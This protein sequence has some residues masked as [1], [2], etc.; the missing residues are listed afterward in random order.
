M[1]INLHFIFLLHLVSLIISNQP[2]QIK[3]FI[4][5]TTTATNS[6]RA[7]IRGIRGSRNNQ[8]DKAYS[9]LS[10]SQITEQLYKLAKSYPDFVT[11][12]TT[13]EEFG[14]KTA[15]SS[16]DCQFDPHHSNH[17]NSNVG[18]YNY[19]LTIQDFIS[20]PEHSTSSQYLP[21]IF[22]SGAV[23]GNERV[24]PA[25]VVETAA[26]LLESA[27]CESLPHV[28]PNH[29]I[30]FNTEYG[31]KLLLQV[32]KGTD[33]RQ[34]LY[35][36]GISNDQRQWLARL[37]STRRI[38]IMPTA[39]ALGYHRNQREEG[40]IDPN[41][42]FP[43]DVIDKRLCMQT[44]AGR[45]INELFRRHLFQIALTFHGGME[46]VS[47]EWG[48]PSYSGKQSPDHLAQVEIGN[49]YASFAGGF[50]GTRVYRSGTMND[51]VYP[52]RGGMVCS[53]FVFFDDIYLNVMMIFI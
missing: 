12:K 38:I 23:H 3:A 10:S 7:T 18:C 32:E 43:F 28:L 35:Q 19:Y 1:S 8:E 41:R 13:Q 2:H 17:D 26:L 21:E 22:L 47:Y 40:Y 48:A 50:V 31:K 15:G 30:D 20:H 37:V 39:N 45:S 49:G 34:K 53:S 33:C 24:G 25:S 46:V 29:N 9:I 4:T 27:F 52:V 5:P 6:T 42:D 36:R 44:I 14:L 51:L 11:L 16:S